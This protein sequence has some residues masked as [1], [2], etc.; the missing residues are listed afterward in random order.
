MRA[1][2]AIALLARGRPV[3]LPPTPS[4]TQALGTNDEPD[5]PSRHPRPGAR[6]RLCADGLRPYPHLR[7]H[8]HRQPGAPDHDHRRRL[9]QLLAVPKP[10]GVDPILSMPIAFAVLFCVGLVLYKLVFEK[11]AA[12]AKYSEMT[13]LLTFGVALC[14]DGLLSTLFTNTQRG[15]TPSYGADAFFIGDIFIPKG[16]LYAGIVSIVIIGALYLFLRYTRFGYAIRATTQNRSAAQLMGVNVGFVSPHHLR[17]RPGARRR[18]GFAHQLHLAVLSGQALGVDRRPHVARRARRHGQA[19]R[20][21]RGGAPAVGHRRVRAGP[22]SARAGRSSP[23]TWRC[24]S[25]C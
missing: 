19:A 1:L 3:P 12:N 15:T 22:I 25:S 13:V 16:Q 9:R 18:R 17:H 23:S 14:G 20:R 21:D 24:S 10:Y 5:H 6:R 8:A 7:R 4:A 11:E 2:N